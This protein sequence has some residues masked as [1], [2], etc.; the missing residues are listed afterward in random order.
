MGAHQGGAERSALRLAA[1]A[2]LVNVDHLAHRLGR[3][4]TRGEIV[5][6]FF[7]RPARALREAWSGRPGGG[8][9]R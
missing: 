7:R 5:A 4:P 2:P 8:A 6:E 1:R 9:R 3:T